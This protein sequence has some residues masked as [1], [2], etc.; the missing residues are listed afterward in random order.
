MN[1]THI[2]HRVGGTRCVLENLPSWLSCNPDIVHFNTGLHDLA[3]NPSG[4]SPPGSYVP[5]EVYGRNLEQIVDVLQRSGAETLVW[6]SST[7]VHDEWH[8]TGDH[9]EDMRSLSRRLEDVRRYN[10]TAAE[11]MRRRSIEI[12]DLFTSIMEEGLEE[13]I[14]ADGVHL[15]AKGAALLGKLVAERIL[16]RL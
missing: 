7:P 3:F 6:A 12:N 11:V 16:A 8:M 15:S 1:V 10:D 4:G 2:P 5:L 13:C 14:L 9:S